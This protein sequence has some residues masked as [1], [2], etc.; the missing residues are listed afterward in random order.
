MGRKGKS[1]TMRVS[2][3]QLQRATK[4]AGRL[5]IQ[6]STAEVLRKALDAGLA[7]LDRQVDAYK[8]PKQVVHPDSDDD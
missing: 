2:P 8:S 1:Y 7:Q 5:P 3:E 6:P 4:I